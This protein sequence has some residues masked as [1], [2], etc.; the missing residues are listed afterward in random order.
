MCDKS[1]VAGR[2][3]RPFLRFVASNKLLISFVCCL[4]QVGGRLS[5]SSFDIAPTLRLAGISNMWCVF[6]PAH[7]I[8]VR[9]PSP[10]ALTVDMYIKSKIAS[11]WLQLPYFSSD[12]LC[13]SFCL[14]VFW[15]CVSG[16]DQNAFGCRV[17][18]LWPWSEEQIEQDYDR[19]EASALQARRC[20][21]PFHS[22]RERVETGLKDTDRVSVILEIEIT[23]CLSNAMYS[24]GQNINSL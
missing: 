17:L 23:Y 19:W 24:I 6:V 9:L 22:P 13:L 8:S 12:S 11:I 3:S 15:L 2:K 5:F 7:A 14:S 18:V 16:M 21:F 1:A 4:Q 20:S 10:R